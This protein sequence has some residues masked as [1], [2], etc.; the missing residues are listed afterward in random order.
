M[1]LFFVGPLD[2]TLRYQSEISGACL[3]LNL[4]FLAPK[5]VFY[6][7]GYIVLCFSF[8][9][10]LFGERRRIETRMKVSLDL[11]VG[12]CLHKIFRSRAYWTR[13]VLFQV[14]RSL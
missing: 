9:V 2:D 7:E 4:R 10:D 5:N 12:K 13:F 1:S 8:L 11:S 6:C 3:A 14:E